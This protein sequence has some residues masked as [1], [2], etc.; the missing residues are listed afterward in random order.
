MRTRPC[1]IFPLILERIYSCMS[2]SGLNAQHGCLRSG[3]YIHN[4]DGSIR[5]GEKHLGTRR[6]WP[7]NG[8]QTCELGK[9]LL[10]NKGTW[11]SYAQRWFTRLVE[12]FNRIL[13][14]FL[15]PST[16]RGVL[17]LMIDVVFILSQSVPRVRHRRISTDVS[18]RPYWRHRTR[19]VELL[20][21]L[22]D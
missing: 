9:Q 7:G 14:V 13:F 4:G 11:N 5:I 1:A 22:L 15:H 20:K 10:A 12:I 19:T 18:S 21:P 16:R 17:F 3:H 2:P 8:L 6:D